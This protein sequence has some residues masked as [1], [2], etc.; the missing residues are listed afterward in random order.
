M[1]RVIELPLTVLFI[2]MSAVC[3][4]AQLSPWF[5]S[6]KFGLVIHW[7][8]ASIWGAEISWPLVCERLPCSLQSENGTMKVNTNMLFD[9]N[10]CFFPHQL[11]TSTEMLRAHRSV[12]L[13]VVRFLL[14][15][16]VAICRAAY[17]S[18]SQR[19]APR[20]FNATALAEIAKDAGKLTLQFDSMRTHFAFLSSLMIRLSLHGANDN[21]C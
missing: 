1:V 8:P 2:S 4:T 5:S 18:L 21:S 10:S 7:A 9:A 3:S 20:A 19:F 14:Q 16:S 17:A 12:C 15:P 11:I 13:C 6:A